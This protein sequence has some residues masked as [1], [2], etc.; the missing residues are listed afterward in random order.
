MGKTLKHTCF[1]ADAGAT[2]CC[3]PGQQHDPPSSHADLFKLPAIR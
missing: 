3:T 2:V 1:V